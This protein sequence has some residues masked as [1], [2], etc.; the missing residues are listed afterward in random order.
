M[1]NTNLNISITDLATIRDLLDTACTRGAFK[2]EEARSVGEVYEKLTNFLQAI[3]KQA[4]AA[5][6]ANQ[7]ADPQGESQ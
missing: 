6:Q 7:S 4:E 3:V 2:A 5:Q 1:E